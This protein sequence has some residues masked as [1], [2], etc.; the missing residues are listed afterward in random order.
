[1]EEMI[2]IEL[3]ETTLENWKRLPDGRQNRKEKRSA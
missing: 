2:C 1:M 3:K